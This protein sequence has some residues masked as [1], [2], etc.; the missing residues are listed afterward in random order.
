LKNVP[1]IQIPSNSTGDAGNW[2]KT[3]FIMVL[4]IVTFI[5]FATKV[6]VGVNLTSNTPDVAQAAEPSA[7]PIS[8]PQEIT[9]QESPAT[10]N[11]SIALV[12]VTGGWVRPQ[13][14]VD[15]SPIIERE[16]GGTSASG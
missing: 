4:F 8:Q 5:W 6:L 1:I 3:F 12:P 11:Q 10:I 14:V 7:V 15:N 9:I 16:V 2:M 13:S